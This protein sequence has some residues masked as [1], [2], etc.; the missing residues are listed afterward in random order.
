I[1]IT[2]IM[3]TI[4]GLD[5]L[6]ID[7]MY[8]VLKR[9]HKAKLPDFSE[10]Y[11]KPE[12]PIAI[13]FGAWNESGVIGR[14]LSFTVN[15]LKYKNYRIFVGVY[16]NDQKTIDVVSKISA[17]DSRI[18][19]VI[20]PQDGPTTKADN[21]NVLY[22]A[23]TDFEKQFGEFEILLVHDAEDFI[24]PRSLKLYNFLIGYKGY[25]G[26]QIPVVPIKSQLGNTIH[27][28]YCDAFAETH[29]KDMI[30]RQEMGT[31]MPF[32]GTG[33]GFHRK[34]MYCIEMINDKLLNQKENNSES[35][36]KEF[37]DPFGRIVQVNP[38]YFNNDEGV[39]ISPEYYNNTKYKDNPFE[40]LEHKPS[41]L[42][43][44]TRKAIN[45]YTASFAAI[46]LLCLSV[47]IYQGTSAGS[48]P[49]PSGNTLILADNIVKPA[50]LSKIDVSNVTP[51][52]NVAVKKDNKPTK[53]VVSDNKKSIGKDK[54]TSSTK[55]KQVTGNK[56]ISSN[57]NFTGKNPNTKN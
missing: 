10:M 7:L 54:S 30:I 56:T 49:S 27:R 21:L 48:Q 17:Q 11:D 46:V 44:S 34:S 39:A 55:V 37:S 25:H 2:T 35:S 43:A 1:W 19:M 28:T 29:T 42:A 20:N 13:T 41:A 23:I 14:T 50:E 51:S 18:K 8:W 9:R 38:E 16:P 4:S 3:L 31:F 40:S 5:D 32:S 53:K 6:Y 26:I 36:N 45:R 52:K 22:A 15:N 57:N 47:I 24:H 12:K 33:M